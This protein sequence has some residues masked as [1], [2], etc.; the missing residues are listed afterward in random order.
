MIL[1]HAFKEWAVIGHALAEGKQSVLI[2]KGGIAEAGREFTVEHNLFWL[3][4]TYTHQQR[5]GIQGSARQCAADSAEHE[6]ARAVY[7]ARFPQ[8]EP[9]FGF[10]DF[11]LFVIEPRSIRFVG[12]FARATSIL[13]KEFASIM[14]GAA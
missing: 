3:F 8:S 1:T 5:A 4:P 9:M 6:A 12:G 11:S 10:A 7:L 2:R 14:Q 13:A